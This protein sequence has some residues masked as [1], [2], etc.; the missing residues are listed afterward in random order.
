MLSR[1]AKHLALSANGCIFVLGQILRFALRLLRTQN[2]KVLYAFAHGIQDGLKP[3]SG[4][5]GLVAA[6]V[7]ILLE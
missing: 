3:C 1:K 4:S 5:S 2:D 7:R 6:W